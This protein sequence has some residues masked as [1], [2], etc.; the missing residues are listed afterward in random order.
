[1]ARYYFQRNSYPLGLEIKTAKVYH[2]FTCDF[3][4]RSNYENLGKTFS[5]EI[6][7]VLSNFYQND[8]FPSR[9]KSVGAKFINIFLLKRKIFKS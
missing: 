6:L 5:L 3:I 8:Y 7:K 1:L 4:A 2:N 9:Y